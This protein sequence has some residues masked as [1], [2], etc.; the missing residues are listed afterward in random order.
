MAS[1]SGMSSHGDLRAQGHQEV[2]HTR[3]WAS[4]IWATAGASRGHRAGP[5][6]GT[7]QLGSSPRTSG[8]RQEH[9]Q[10]QGQ[11]PW[12]MG[13]RSGRGSGCESSLEVD[14]LRF[15]LSGPLYPPG[16]WIRVPGR[17]G[18]RAGSAGLGLG[19]RGA[20]VAW[21]VWCGAILAASPFSSYLL[22][23]RL[24][25]NITSPHLSAT[26]SQSTRLTR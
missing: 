21:V 2:A 15:P 8:L 24:I 22:S 16:G 7:G 19:I 5:W 26:P 4:G 3:P 11:G 1:S 13:Q 14:C 6:K 18:V 17:L 10:G 9:R 12:M 20:G 23:S 25:S